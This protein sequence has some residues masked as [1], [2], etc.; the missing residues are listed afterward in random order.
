MIEPESPVT[1]HIDCATYPAFLLQSDEGKPLGPYS[2]VLRHRHLLQQQRVIQRPLATD[3]H[4]GAKLTRGISVELTNTDVVGASPAGSNPPS[5]HAVAPLDVPAA[6]VDAARAATA[7]LPPPRSTNH[8]AAANA[9]ASSSKLS[10]RNVQGNPAADQTPEELSIDGLHVVRHSRS[11]RSRG[12]KTVWFAS[13]GRDL[14]QTPPELPLSRFA[15]L[16]VH[17]STGGARQAWLRTHALKWASID[18]C[19]PHPYLKG[20]MFNI[21]TNGEP[22]WVTKD[23]IRTYKGRAKKREQDGQVRPPTS[24]RPG[25]FVSD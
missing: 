2:V 6:P 20:Y 9:V 16:Y 17:T 12:E 15:D 22:S 1:I 7:G 19:Q 25:K 10:A 5:E 8:A 4:A 14:L 18:L 13:S 11:I 23:T 21:C 24:S 3:Q